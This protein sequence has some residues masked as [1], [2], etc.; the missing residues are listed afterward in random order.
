MNST[1]TAFG[2]AFLFGCTLA[3]P[4]AAQI[5]GSI[6]GTAEAYLKQ[7]PPV[8]QAKVFTIPGLGNVMERIAI[9][10]DGKEIYF[11]NMGSGSVCRIS[12]DGKNWGEWKTLF[13][14]FIMPALSADNTT[15]FMEDSSAHAWFSRKKNGE[16]STPTQLFTGDFKQHYLQQ[17]SAGT[18]FATSDPVTGTLGDVSKIVV[19][20]AQS[21]PVSLG[22]PV[23][24]KNSGFDFFMAPD[25]S[26]IITVV[27]SGGSGNL[28]LC[29]KKPDG[30]WT[31]PLNLGAGVNSG[32]WEYAPYVSPDGKYL[33]FTRDGAGATFW[34][35][36]DTILADVKKQAGM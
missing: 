6:L 9:S 7:V 17:V 29:L 15:L 18:Y 1:T 5:Q 4:L 16:W 10:S 21:K 28:N 31:S 20:G 13:K 11:S 23:N 26:Y 32:D 33:F 22:A 25:E 19:T 27:R 2:F 3:V 24:G 12:Y 30:T 34:V 36:F 35:R 14:G 8:A